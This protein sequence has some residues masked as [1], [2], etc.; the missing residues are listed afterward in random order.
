MISFPLFR[1]FCLFP[2]RFLSLPSFIPIRY[3]LVLVLLRVLSIVRISCFW[4]VL[5]FPWIYLFSWVRMLTLGL[6]GRMSAESLP[7][8][9]LIRAEL[10]SNGSPESRSESTSKLSSHQIPRSPRVH[11]S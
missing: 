1:S 7:Q 6:L 9:Q 3:V 2:T 8:V 10:T 4:P 5:A 11:Y